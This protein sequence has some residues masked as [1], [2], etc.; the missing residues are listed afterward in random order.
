MTRVIVVPRD[1]RFVLR[2]DRDAPVG[3]RMIR[4][5]VPNGTRMPPEE[6]EFATE[7]EARKAAMDWNVY[8]VAVDSQKERA[9]QK[10]V[11]FAD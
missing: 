10:N 2:T 8:L 7:N 6:T 9:K 11:R 5:T 3:N 4:G 1:G